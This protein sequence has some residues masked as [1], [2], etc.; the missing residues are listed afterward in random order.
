M[1]QILFIDYFRRSKNA[2]NEQRSSGIQIESED[3]TMPVVQ[4]S[5]Q[6]AAT[7]Q[8]K[9]ESDIKQE[10]NDLVDIPASTYR[11]STHVSDLSAEHEAGNEFDYSMLNDVKDE[12]KKEC[13]DKK[14]E[15]KSNADCDEGAAS[16]Q[17]DHQPQAQAVDDLFQ[18]ER[19]RMAQST[20]NGN[21]NANQ[22][23]L[24]VHK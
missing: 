5:I 20:Q 19:D 23:S 21:V 4:N 8:T 2:A 12:M 13:D 6:S 15:S 17:R 18:S 11:N 22:G 10:P 14:G 9:Q 3:P 7:I 24:K 16:E 1:C